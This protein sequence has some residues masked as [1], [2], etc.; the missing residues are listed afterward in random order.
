MDRRKPTRLQGTARLATDATTALADLVEAMHQR[1]SPLER[2]SSAAAGRTTGVTGWVYRS[3]R[4]TARIAGGTADALLGFLGA[5]LSRSGTSAPLG[6]GE[7]REAII[8]VLNGIIGDHLAETANPLATRMCFRQGGRSLRLEPGSRLASLPGARREILVLMHGLCMNDMQWKRG[9]HDHG[10]ALARESGMTPVYL[11]Y[12]TGMRIASNGRLLAAGLQRLVE[13]WPRPVDRV[14]L[15]GHSMGGLVARSALHFAGDAGLGW[16]ARV[17]HLVCLGTPHQGAPL[18]RM[19]NLVEQVLGA[20]PY[21]APLA[22]LARLRSAGVTDL[23]HGAIRED[24]RH[25]PLPRGCRNF[26]LA[27]SL[28]RKADDLGGRLLG[29]GLVPVR[30]ALGKHPD[31]AR[32]LRFPGRHQAVA[33]KTGHLELLRSPA[34]FEVLEGW[35]GDPGR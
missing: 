23:R 15:L 21:T 30:S 3:V 28:G 13:A 17:S 7:T 14:V 1:I 26:A 27:G 8:A 16:T 9:G 5:A 19:G 29:D 11:R 31:A 24:G 10:E 12:N 20:T 22:R 33:W 4:G 32:T 25:V 6:G 2:W 34:V 35:I 18:E